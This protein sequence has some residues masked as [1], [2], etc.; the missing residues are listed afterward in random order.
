MKSV[1]QR[2][3]KKINEESQTATI[4][5]T[6]LSLECFQKNSGRTGIVKSVKRNN[7]RALTVKLGRRSKIARERKVPP[8][9]PD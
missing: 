6:I 2:A 3:K 7:C 5:F 8:E 9:Q 4:A 1:L